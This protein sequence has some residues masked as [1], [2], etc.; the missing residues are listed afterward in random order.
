[1]SSRHFRNQL[2]SVLDWRDGSLDKF[3]EFVRVWTP[4]VQLRGP[5]VRSSADGSEVDVFYR[6]GRGPKELAWA[7][8]GLQVW[9]QILLYAYKLKGTGTLV[10]DEPDVYLHADLQY[11]L[12]EL[13]DSLECQAILATHSPELLAS[14]PE[15]SVLW[16][17]K[18]GRSAVEA[19]TGSALTDLA[20]S[21]G[22]HF[23]IRLAR[24]LKAKLAL[25][26]EGDDMVIL[27][28]LARAAGAVEIVSQARIAVVPLTGTTNRK[29][30]ESFRWV[31][32]NLL[33]GAIAGFVI[34]DRDY[35][36]DDEVAEIKLELRSAGLTVHIWE[37]HE[38]ESYLLVPRTLSRVS[39][40]STDFVEET[41]EASAEAI[42]NSA[43]A[44]FLAARRQAS[45]TKHSH[46]TVLTKAL[47]DFELLWDDPNTR[48]QVCPA[49]EWLSEVNKRL[50]AAQLSAASARALARQMSSHEIPGE[51]L[52]V[53]DEVVEKLSVP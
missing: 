22:T 31:T 11:R 20:S 29:R 23:N 8:D 50:Q 14:A 28:H 51:V 39:G 52:R 10:F 43:L 5:E 37:R 21:M 53:F 3:L 26:V 7:G 32:E 24:V 13:I 6:E 17:S 45:P 4:E 44:D 38:L 1:M 19:P 30:L 9:F 16:I 36:T 41:L 48:L 15:E 25:F 34:L 42:R 33:L 49:K 46:K 2:L 12:I 27:R 35:M 18:S 40:A 47:A